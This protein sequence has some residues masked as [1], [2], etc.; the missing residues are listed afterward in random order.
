MLLGEFAWSR[1][2]KEHWSIWSWFLPHAER[3]RNDFI[4]CS[5]YFMLNQIETKHHSGYSGPNCFGPGGQEVTQAHPTSTN[6][7]ISRIMR[8]ISSS[9][10]GYFLQ[11]LLNPPQTRFFF[12]FEL[13]LNSRLGSTMQAH[14]TICIYLHYSLP[15]LAMEAFTAFAFILALAAGFT[16]AFAWGFGVWVT[17]LI[18]IILNTLHIGKWCNCNCYTTQDVFKRDAAN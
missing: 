17:C 10:T 1:V 4:S 7:Q 12:P 18:F 11:T 13:D 14:C 16:F 15:R 2:K 8:R 9:N 5:C 3:N 6:Q